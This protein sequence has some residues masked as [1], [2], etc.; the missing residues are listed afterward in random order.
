[1]GRNAAKLALVK[2]SVRRMRTAVRPAR[3]GQAACSLLALFFMPA[4]AAEPA[5]SPARPAPRNAEAD[6]ATYDRCLKLAKQDP[7]AAQTLAQAWRER[8]GAH[9]ADHAAA[10]ALVVRKQY[11]EP[12]TGLEA[13]AQKMPR[14]PASLRAEVLDQA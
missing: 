4:A 11:K 3:A 6:A 7:A 10:R 1:F 9:P 8:G 14:A 2:G 5:R 13:L 12:A